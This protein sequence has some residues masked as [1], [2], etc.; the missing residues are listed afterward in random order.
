MST[1]FLMLASLAHAVPTPSPSQTALYNAMK[2][3]ESTP[4]CDQLDRYSKTVADDL[5]W[6]MDNANQPP[7]VGIRAAQCILTHHAKAKADVIDTWVTDPK[8]RGL[9][10]MVFGMLDVLPEETSVRVAK[11]ALAGPLAADA[12]VRIKKSEKPAIRALVPNP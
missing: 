7:W 11:K 12:K 9:A 3:R 8:R 5:L 1:L 2:M 4:D 10:I 6:L